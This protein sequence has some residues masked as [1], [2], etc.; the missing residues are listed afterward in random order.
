MNTLRL[1]TNKPTG[2]TTVLII[3]FLFFAN[4]T[5]VQG[6][7]SGNNEG[8]RGDGVCR[9]EKQSQ[10]TK[11]GQGSEFKQYMHKSNQP[12]AT[13]E[14]RQ[15][16]EVRKKDLT[17]LVN[18]PKFEIN[19]SD[20]EAL[21]H[22]REEEK[23]AHDVYITLYKKWNNKTFDNISKS[24]EKHM[25]ILKTLMDKYDITDSIT[26]IEV[27]VFGTKEFQD[28]Y[29]T[30]II[31][32]SISELEAVKVGATIED[33]DIYD[34][35]RFM[36]K[37]SNQDILNVFNNLNNASTNHLQAF[38]SQ[39]ESL[40]GSYS[41]QHITNE[42]LQEILNAQDT[43]GGNQKYKQRNDDQQRSGSQKNKRYQGNNNYA[44]EVQ[45]IKK[46]SFLKRLFNFF[47]FW[48]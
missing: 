40:G 39:V 28:L 6:C 4:L 34:L 13:R 12:T 20:I 11:D 9:A 19:Q 14:H 41:A 2:P 24:E 16:L 1:K 17:E 32:G 44:E 10:R 30:L 25:E 27:G 45:S 22:M 21:E 7:E 3:A 23:I 37:T 46:Q 42:R 8:C 43:H 15:D 38:N 35:E 36:K 47:A 29:N 26:S 48:R 5:F 33:L 31:K 18:G